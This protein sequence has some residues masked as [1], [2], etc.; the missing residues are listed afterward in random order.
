MTKQQ[1]VS[2]NDF[3]GKLVLPHGY[4][5]YTIYKGG[6]KLHYYFFG[7]ADELIF[8]G[9]DYRPS[10]LYP[11]IDSVE[12]VVGCLSFLTLQDGDTDNE[13]FANYTP[14]QLAF[15]NSYECEELSMLAHDFEEYAYIDA[16]DE[17][18]KE[19]TQAAKDYFYA[20]YTQ[21]I[22]Q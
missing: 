7:K 5:L 21:E 9:N 8:S 12:A 20:N 4:E 6:D 18:G 1:I 22:A 3:S 14:A 13:Y 10:P 19:Y 11:A 17:Q 16:Q 15:S 2:H